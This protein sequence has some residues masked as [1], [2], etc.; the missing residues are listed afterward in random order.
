VKEIKSL[1]ERASRY[2]KSAEILIKEGDY[3]SSVSRTYYVMF[4]SVQALLLTKNLSFSSH[5]GVVSAFGRHFI[6]TAIF[7]KEMGRELNRAFEKRQIGDYEYTFVIASGGR[8]RGNTDGWEEICRGNSSAFKGEKN[9]VK[10]ARCLTK[11]SFL[12]G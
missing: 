9:A 7:P 3:E 5:K 1:I 6:K 11:R 12:Q 8:S 4:Y 2:L 10:Y